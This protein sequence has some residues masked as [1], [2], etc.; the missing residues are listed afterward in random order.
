MVEECCGR[1][2]W[3][4]AH[5]YL[6]ERRRLCK[7]CV[8]LLLCEGTFKVLIFSF[9]FLLIQRSGENWVLLLAGDSHNRPIPHIR[10]CRGMGVPPPPFSSPLFPSPV[11]PVLHVFL[12][13]FVF[14]LKLIS[15]FFFLK[16]SARVTEN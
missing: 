12:P 4:H 11:T 7:G 15:V 10:G 9:F 14:F 3:L 8:S 5:I 1:C 13:S 6:E 16:S 2:C